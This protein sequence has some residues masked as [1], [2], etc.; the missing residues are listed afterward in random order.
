MQ[1]D[2]SLEKYRLLTKATN[3]AVYDYDFASN[4]TEWN[5]NIRLFGYDPAD[6]GPGIEWWAD[7]IHP[8]DRDCVLLELDAA[9][10]G[11]SGVFNSN[12]RFRCADGRYRQTNDR[13][14]VLKDA[15]GA[16]KRLVGAIQDVHLYEQMFR[17]NPQPMWAF[18]LETLRF[19]AVNN[20]SIK[21]YGYT[22][23]E[24][25]AMT[26]SDVRPPEDI[27]MLLATVNSVDREHEG[28]SVW[29][30]FTKDG[31][32]LYVEVRT[33]E[34]DWLGQPA[35]MAVMKD[36]TRRVGL[37]AQLRETQKMDAI[38]MMAGGVA[39]DFNN[40]L[41]VVNGHARVCL[42]R[43]H[44]ADPL[45]S[46]I[47]AIAQAGAKAEQLTRQLLALARCQVLQPQRIQVNDVIVGVGMLLSR[48]V[49]PAVQIEY[50][51][52]P[53]LTS[54]KA[55][56]T[57]IEQVLLNLVANAND[58]IDG[59]GLIRIGTTNVDMDD[60]HPDHHPGVAPG[61]YVQ[62]SV[63]D[64]GTGM[65]DEVKLHLFEPFFSTKTA[66][67]GTGLGLAAVYGIVRQS[68][69]WIRVQ[70]ELG[71]GARFRIYFPELLDGEESPPDPD[72][73][74]RSPG[75]TTRRHCVLVVD[76]DPLLRNLISMELTATG[77]LVVE[78]S[79]G[80]G[81]LHAVELGGI[82]AVVT[83]IVMPEKEGLE[84]IQALR[85]QNPKL[86]VIAISGAFSGQFLKLAKSFGAHA[87][88]QKPLDMDALIAELR[89][90]LD[91]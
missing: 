48:L 2:N 84:T 50:S 23:E 19:L 9:L 59:Q 54:I 65:T 86:P 89:R 13:G 33:H 15:S 58:A 79:N 7:R 36:V 55:D 10:S 44:R 34:F 6:A 41:S 17:H 57:Q 31:R 1:A 26:I 28:R 88:L 45:R 32:L 25:L 51:L 83:D 61:D 87:A 3:D 71:E 62:L 69:G 30:H 4:R 76:D 75:A 43:M 91:A 78:A 56:P 60:K 74:P 37:E 24:F 72:A 46:E 20:A 5:E 42:K 77:F 47:D 81:A 27:P 82:D 85:K 64:N 11:A 38:G 53:T 63:E 70:S 22:R 67:K 18:H 49:A 8:E 39:H 80:I 66:D 68:G 73:G 35:R 16:P 21:L 12:Y 40:L 29:R 14:F 90:L 52:S